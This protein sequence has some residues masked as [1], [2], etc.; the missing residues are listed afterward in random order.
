MWKMFYKDILEQTEPGSAFL[1][2]LEV[3]I[4]WLSTNQ[5]APW[6]IPWMYRSAQ[7]YSGYVT[8]GEN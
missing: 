3:Q 5:V 7:K 2:H 8:A 4:F 1:E 6:W